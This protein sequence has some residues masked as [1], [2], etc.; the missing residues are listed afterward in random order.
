MDYWLVARWLRDKF[1]RPKMASRSHGCNRI[2]PP[3]KILCN[4]AQGLPVLTL[5]HQGHAFKICCHRIY[6]F[7]K[8][9]YRDRYSPLGPRDPMTSTLSNVT[10]VML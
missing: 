6:P 9:L 8:Y 1:R 5:D 4:D 3:R 7:G 10:I 2:E